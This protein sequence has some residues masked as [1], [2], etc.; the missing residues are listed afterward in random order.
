MAELYSLPD[1][2]NE[3]KLN[4]LCKLEYGK[5]L[6]TTIMLDYGYKVFGA[7]GVIGYYSEFNCENIEVLIS[8]RGAN[9]GVVNLSPKESFVTNNSIR[10]KDLDVSST[11]KMFLYY[12]LKTYDKSKIVTGSAQPQVTIQSL[13]LVS[14]PLPPLE[15]Q[16]RIVAKL[17][18]LFAKIDK[19]I[20]LHQKN[21]DEADIFMASVLNDVFVELEEKYEKIPLFDVADVNRG[22]SKHR[23]RNDKKLF[24]GNYPFIQTGDV[25]NANK[26]IDTFSETYSEFGLSQ[27]KLWKKGTICMTIAANI[28]DVAILNIDSCFPDSVVGIYSENNSNDFLYYFLLTL[29]QQLESQATTTAQM[30]INLKILQTIG[31]P[32]PPLKTQQKVVSYLDEISNKMEKIKQIQKEKMQSLKELKASILDKAFKGEL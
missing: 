16:K 12:F 11:D 22:K 15:E 3:K 13:D 2:W 27:S 24:G 29:K 14:I 26:Y 4:T 28:G 20:A 8:C 5:N 7:N 6:P 9:S 23:P 21:I 31:V 1:G 18:I 30:N 32:L 25:R 19:A 17:D 10:C